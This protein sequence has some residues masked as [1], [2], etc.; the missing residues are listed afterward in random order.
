[1]ALQTQWR[2]TAT[3]AGIFYSGLDYAA[4]EALLRVRR[5]PKRAELLADLQV[6]EIAALKGLNKRD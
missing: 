4:A 5:T 3:M 6:M 2:I 1:M